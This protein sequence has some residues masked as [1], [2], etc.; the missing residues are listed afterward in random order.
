[1][2]N[3]GN[4]GLEELWSAIDLNYKHIVLDTYSWVEETY[5]SYLIGDYWSKG[6]ILRYDDMDLNLR[7]TYSGAQ[8]IGALRYSKYKFLGDCLR[9]LKS[10]VF[11][12]FCDFISNAKNNYYSNLH[13]LIND[14][15]TLLGYITF[16]YDLMLE[17]ALEENAFPFRYVNVNENVGD[18]TFFIGD[19]LI[20]KLHGSLNWQFVSN[21]NYIIQDRKVLPI[22]P[23]YVSDG[24]FREPAIIPPTLFKQEINDETKVKEPLT[25][26]I[27]QQWRAAIRVLT[28]A[29]R[30]IIVG[31]SFPPTDFHAKRI[32]QIAMMRRKRNNKKTK[33]LYCGGGNPDDNKT[34]EETM[35]KLENIFMLKRGEGIIIKNKFEE[36]CDSKELK[37]FIDSQ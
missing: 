18:Y 9:Q 33:I 15:S 35:K 16:N 20:I 6:G 21:T 17:D 23:F 24:N 32:F 4:I 7:Q 30:W 25:L 1:L 29:D 12:S 14:K 2:H 8:K 5:D 3:I 36:L 28:D 11:Y 22:T 34:M 19:Y 31:Y 26:T 37:E 27:L 13:N 10:L